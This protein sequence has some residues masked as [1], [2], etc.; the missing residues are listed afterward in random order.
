MCAKR[1]LSTELVKTATVNTGVGIYSG[2]RQLRPELYQYAPVNDDGLQLRVNYADTALDS[3][4]QTFEKVIVAVHGCPGYYTNFDSLI[5]HFRHTKVRVIAPNLP[6]FGHTRSTNTFWHSTE[7]KSAFLRDF[8][9]Q[10]G[11]TTVDCLI[12][13]SFG[14]QTI[15]AFWEKV[16]FCTTKRNSSFYL[17]FLSVAW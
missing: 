2:L 4:E 15:A 9:D 7:E 13:H 5:E 1:R 11:I 12:S 14:I 3:T 10:L 16:P 8:L 17:P 6:D